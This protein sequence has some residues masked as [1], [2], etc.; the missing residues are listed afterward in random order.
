MTHFAVELA[1]A[2]YGRLKV[3]ST[4][5]FEVASGEMLVVLGS[6][7]AGKSTTLRAVMGVI[8]CER[9]SLVL[10]G[11]ELAGL[12]PWRLPGRGVVLVPDGSRCYPNLSVLD[13][14]RGAYVATHARAR[15]AGFLAELEVAFELFPVLRERRAVAAGAL[16]GGQRQMVAVAR[17]LM[18]EPR[19]LLLDE[20]SAGLAPKVVEELFAALAKIKAGRGCA[21]VMAEQN[22]G[23]AMRVADHCLVLE[24]GHVALRGPVA[25]V[26]QRAELRSVYLGL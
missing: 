22:V 19:V 9:R 21:I 16:S 5:A 1:G 6:N 20:P 15:E 4:V 8:A 24:E 14:L 25:E 17:A 13:N 18:A 23:Y 11:A 2:S 7:G 12:A 10:D 3:I 26:V